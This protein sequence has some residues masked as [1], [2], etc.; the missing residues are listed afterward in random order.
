[1]SVIFLLIPL[2]IVIAACFLGAFIWAVRSGQYED[3]CTPSMRVLLEEADAAMVS[4]FPLNGERS[5]A[6]GGNVVA[7]RTGEGPEQ[8]HPSPS[9]PLPVEGR[10]RAASVHSVCAEGVGFNTATENASS[11]HS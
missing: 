6:R 5:G 1:M 8:H 3:T 10:G 4:P 11:N 7:C 9:F 2:S